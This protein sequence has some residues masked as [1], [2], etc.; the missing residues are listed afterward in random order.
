MDIPVDNFKLS[1]SLDTRSSTFWRAKHCFLSGVSKISKMVYPDNPSFCN[2]FIKDD[3]FIK[4]HGDLVN[5]KKN[6]TELYLAG[7][8][9]VSSVCASILAKSLSNDDIRVSVSNCFENDINHRETPVP[10]HRVQ[11][12]KKKESRG[13]N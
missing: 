10:A 5:L 1:E 11:F 9:D 13:Q 12:G 6:V 7:S 4:E 2:R 8:K 3:E